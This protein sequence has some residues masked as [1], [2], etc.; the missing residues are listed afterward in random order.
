[1]GDEE[2]PYGMLAARF[3]N[4]V[5]FRPQNVLIKYR[6]DEQSGRPV[7]VIPFRSASEE[8]ETLFS[9]C[10]ELNP[11]N[12]DRS[13]IIRD[14]AWVKQLWTQ[15]RGA[16]AAIHSDFHRSG[17]QSGRG[18]A[19]MDWMSAAEQARWVYHASNKSRLNDTATTYSFAIFDKADFEENLGKEMQGGAGVDSSLSGGSGKKG[20]KKDSNSSKARR[21]A[22]RNKGRRGK[23]GDND[24]SKL[25]EVL[26]TAMKSEAREKQLRFLMEF[27]SQE[28]KTMALT[29]MR[30][31][32]AAGTSSNK[33]PAAA[34]KEQLSD[35]EDSR[36]TNSSS[37]SDN[38]EDLSTAGGGG[39]THSTKKKK[40]RRNKRPNKKSKTSIV[41][42]TAGECY[43]GEI[44]NADQKCSNCD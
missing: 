22:N 2:D 31:L 42:P 36:S 14:G 8:T 38:S 26:E 15:Q 30:A 16:L 24:E 3:N 39:G 12:M 17:Q 25:A 23:E 13:R 10:K 37:S 33:K 4:W 28:D 11:T 9:K 20:K 6:H 21:E 18:E 32:V 27:G 1:M 44:L 19:E 35:D 43:C 40:A 34:A 41:P 5:D 7:P 29:E